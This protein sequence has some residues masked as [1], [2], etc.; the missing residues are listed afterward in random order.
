MNTSEKVL[1]YVDK[2]VRKEILEAVRTADVPL[3]KNFVEQFNKSLTRED[4]INFR[5]EE[6]GSGDTILH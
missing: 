2:Q 3:L 1:S 6:K 5:D 4:Q